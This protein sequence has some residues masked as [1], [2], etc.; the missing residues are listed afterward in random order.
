MTEYRNSRFK[1]RTDP[2]SYDDPNWIL[3]DAG[4]YYPRCEGATSENIT[5][6]E[7]DRLYAI[8]PGIVHAQYYK[9][10][11]PKYY[12]YVLQYPSA[13]PNCVGYVWGRWRELLQSDPPISIGNAGQFVALNEGRLSMG[14]IP[15]FGAIMCWSSPSGGYGHVAVV[16]NIVLNEDGSYTVYTSESEYGG[17]RFVKRSY[18]STD[19]YYYNYSDYIFQK[20]IYC[21]YFASDSDGTKP[22]INSAMQFVSLCS[23]HKDIGYEWTIKSLNQRLTN[24]SAGYIYACAKS[25]NLIGRA[26]APGAITPSDMIKSGLLLGL[27]NMESKPAMGDIVVFRNQSNQIM[28]LGVVEKINEDSIYIITGGSEPDDA[29][30]RY[31]YDMRNLTNVSYY[32]PNWSSEAASSSY[33]SQIAEIL[34]DTFKDDTALIRQISSATSTGEPSIGSSNIKLSIINNSLSSSFI[35]LLIKANGLNFDNNSNITY[36]T[37]NLSQNARI[38]V[39]FFVSSG[40][41]YAA[42]VGICAN[43]K[44]E[45]NFRPDAIGDRGQS[46]GIAQWY[47]RRGQKMKEYVGDDWA[48]DYSGQLEY[49]LNDIESYNLI[50]RLGVLDNTSEGAQDAAEIICREF[51]APAN[52]DVQVNIRRGYAAEMWDSLILIM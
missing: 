24:W 25:L 28:T 3:R 50:G 34:S 35:A 33:S 26:F 45:S 40:L 30:D 42:A 18:N 37:D 44:A 27:G 13:L 12:K 47:S 29:M 21:P 9:D 52:I 5:K 41:T 48:T 23:D 16:E 31:K 7:Y 2:P 17:R 4:G 11:P 14:D 49:L 39:E 10:Q 46:F 51:E 19:N 8:N 32:R 1:P 38:A 6:D 22:P 20:F 15:R 43:I 36:S